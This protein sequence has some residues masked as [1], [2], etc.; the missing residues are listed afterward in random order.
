MPKSSQ[1]LPPIKNLDALTSLLKEAN[2][3]V[4]KGQKAGKEYIYGV[5]LW[6]GDDG[7][8]VNVVIFDD[9]KAT[10]IPPIVREFPGTFSDEDIATEV[11]KI[12]D[13]EKLQFSSA[14]DFRYEDGQQSE[15]K[16]VALFYPSAAGTEVVSMT[17]KMSTFGGFGDTGMARDEDLAWIENEAQARGYPGY[18]N[19]PN[20]DE[21]FGWRLKKDDVPY[22]ACRWDYRITP[23][24]YLAKPTTLITVTNPK[25]G[26][27]I[28]ARPIDWGPHDDTNRV[29]DLSP[30]VA[31]KLK[32]NTDDI[33][34]VD[35]P[36]PPKVPAFL[37]KADAPVQSG[38][39]ATGGN[40]P[41]NAGVF[42]IDSDHW[43]VGVKRE[44]I[45]GG[46]QMS[47]CRFLV[48]HFTNGASAESSIVFWR[49][50][51]AK[52]ASAHVVIDRDGTVYQCRPFNHTCGHAGASTWK[53]VKPTLNVC[54]IG[55]ELA[56]AGDDSRLAKHFTQLPMLTAKHKNGG[57][58]ES[59]EAFP[60]AQL[61]AC[62]ALSRALVARYRLEDVIGHD[63]IAPDRKNDP[64]PAFPMADLRV[65]CGFPAKIA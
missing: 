34:K 38:G 22:I 57:P 44:P 42:E 65:A 26:Q 59:W 55:I 12:E 10:P 16:V 49:T 17:G 30:F 13:A 9:A 23:K 39:G 31:T 14:Y 7:Q 25:T 4:C 53:G 40:A 52:G 41:G 5:A 58:M 48:I 27:S 29:A 35:I 47:K 60:E 33:V 2:E 32:L 1:S 50:P 28:Q 56:N 37:A 63:D 20:G 8:S 36:L 46:Q 51:A 45:A 54:S 18:F 24:S 21:G 19:P 43:L 62:T 11:M 64:G 61:K 6:T 3:I 15:M